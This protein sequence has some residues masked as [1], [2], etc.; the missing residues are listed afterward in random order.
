[1]PALVMLDEHK[2]DFRKL[3]VP[4]GFRRAIATRESS[5]VFCGG[6]GA[7]ISQSFEKDSLICT[8]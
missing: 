7:A 2:A 1:M 6:Q 4:A 8:D 5:A 3:V